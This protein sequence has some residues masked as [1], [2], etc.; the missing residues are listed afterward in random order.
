MKRSLP[1]LAL[2]FLAGCSQNPSTT[3][4]SAMSDANNPPAPAQMIH[5]SH[6][7]EPAGMYFETNANGKTYV[8]GYVSTAAMIRAGNIPSYMVEKANFNG[9][10]GT[11]VFEEDG[12]GL[13]A[14]LEN[15]YKNTHK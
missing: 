6:E 14:R 2:G 12:K 15:D 1:V 9:G 4:P 11:V 7:G 8:T 5:P 3:Q 13:E 10:T